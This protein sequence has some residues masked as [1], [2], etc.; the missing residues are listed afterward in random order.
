MKIVILGGFLGSGKTTVLLKLAKTLISESKGKGT[1]VVIIENEIGDVSVD[2]G[3]LGGY[4]VRELFSGCVCC[5]LAGDLT[6]AANEIQEKYAPDFL[7]IEAT[8]VAQPKN[9]IKIMEQYAKAEDIL[10]IVLADAYRWEDLMDYMDVFIS[11]QLKGADF[12]LLNKCDLV[13]EET[14][15]SA[16]G[17]IREMNSEA[18]ILKISAAGED[19]YWLDILKEALR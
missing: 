12:V 6:V 5:T 16:C 2:T 3:L 14:A 11:N 18:R 8:G 17:D 19:D 7:I 13:S 15:D 10:D 4:E 1:P 9:I